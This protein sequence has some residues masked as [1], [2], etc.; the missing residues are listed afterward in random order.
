MVK[1]IKT[2]NLFGGWQL[3]WELRVV[4]SVPRKKVTTTPASKFSS[5]FPYFCKQRQLF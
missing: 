3:I 5:C 2:Q 4:V 1:D